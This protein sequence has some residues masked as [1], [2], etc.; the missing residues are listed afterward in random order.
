MTA[1]V[2]SAEFQEIQTT[3]EIRDVLDRRRT[4][5]EAELTALRDGASPKDVLFLRAAAS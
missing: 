2:I 3:Q 4:L 1:I 5:R